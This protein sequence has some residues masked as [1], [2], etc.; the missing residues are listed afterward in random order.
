MKDN[1]NACRI[2]VAHVHV[3]CHQQLSC[4]SDSFLKNCG[5]PSTAHSLGFHL[6]CE[7]LRPTV[8]P[9]ASS[10]QHFENLAFYVRSARSVAIFLRSR[11]LVRS[12]KR[13]V[14]PRLLWAIVLEVQSR[15]SG[16]IYR[17]QLLV[18]RWP[19]ASA[20]TDALVQCIEHGRS[21]PSPA[22]S[23]TP[24]PTGQKFTFRRQCRS[25]VRLRRF[26][27]LDNVSFRFPTV[28]RHPNCQICV[29][30]IIDFLS[31]SF[32]RNPSPTLY[33]VCS[34][35][36]AAKRELF[37]TRGTN[38]VFAPRR[39]RKMGAFVSFSEWSDFPHL[40]WL[41]LLSFFVLHGVA[42]ALL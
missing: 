20:P 35:G 33:S 29:V 1:F 10:R 19:L 30:W 7:E 4:L 13:L 11:V 24:F 6:C 8:A 41:Q 42:L 14:H 2:H 21:T 9:N 12:R 27:T 36:L 16:V 22:T 5:A 25:K 31:F 34:C 15:R 28:S 38:A 39:S 23:S 18:R 37:L 3:H 32:Y 17:H 26:G 40:F